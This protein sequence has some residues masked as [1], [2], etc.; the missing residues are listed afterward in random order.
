MLDAENFKKNYGCKRKRFSS[1]DPGSTPGISTK[2]ICFFTL[3][4]VWF[5]E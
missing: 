4:N 2:K 5:I 1:L 3:T